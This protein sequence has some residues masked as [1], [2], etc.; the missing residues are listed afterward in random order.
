[1]DAHN[2]DA[3][4]TWRMTLGK[5]A[6]L[7]P[8][9]FKRAALT[10][11]PSARRVRAVHDE[12][13]AWAAAR[14]GKATV[15]NSSV[16]DIVDDAIAG[17]KTAAGHRAAPA[18]WEEGEPAAAPEGAGA[19][20]P[21][22][23][24]APAPAHSKPKHTHAKRAA[25]KKSSPAASPSS[26][27][28]FPEEFA[29]TK[30]GAEYGAVVG[31]IHEQSSSCASCW[32]F[33]TADSIAATYAVDITKKTRKRMDAPKL[34]ILQLMDCD[35]DDNACATGN[36]YTSFNWI[37]K[38]GGIALASDYD[39]AVPSSSQDDETL[40][41]AANV[42]S[43]LTT[44]GMCDLKM[45]AGN[46]ALMRAIYETGPVAVG[47][48]GERLHFYDG[49]V[50]TAKE[51]PPAGAG[52]SSINHAAL[53]VGWGVENGMKYWLVRN[54]Y[55]EDFG[56]KGYF[57]LERAEPHDHGLFGT[58]GLLFESVYPIVT[59]VGVVMDKKEMEAKCVEGSVFK[60]E[61]FRDET[62]N[63]GTLL[64]NEPA[65]R[66]AIEAADAFIET[67]LGGAVTIAK[68]EGVAGAAL[69]GATV[70]AAVAVVVVRRRKASANVAFG[71]AERLLP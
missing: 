47:I 60:Q 9:E 15:N 67:A 38:N 59:K 19:P 65:S 35:K 32:A 63:P 42:K 29:W 64:G 66:G 27:G 53:V 52:I 34:S 70:A 44:P 16:E 57:K 13:K 48:N 30:P 12:M 14:L 37:E 26:H 41:C 18:A 45:T 24:P 4:K 21:A 8:E 31:P 62:A 33:V 56:E 71:E 36:M 3:T 55:G 17:E 28:G 23:E 39:A 22:H 5:H 69:I 50:I 6:D 51:C 1:M 58:C 54:T 10:Y 7:A 40:Q 25:S 46:E 68:R 61:Y 11:K 49:G 43:T 20:E 2:A